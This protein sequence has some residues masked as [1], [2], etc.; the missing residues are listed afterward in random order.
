MILLWTTRFGGAE[1][2]IFDTVEEAVRAAKYRE[3]YGEAG[4]VGIERDGAMLPESEWQP[5]WDGLVAEDDAKWRSHPKVLARVMVWPSGGGRAAVWGEVCEGDH[6]DS[7]AVL[8]K[9]Q[10][11]F[12]ADRCYLEI[13]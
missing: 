9:A 4:F 2:D 5:I 10:A 11:R 1:L 13:R 7:A 3:D 6:D 8:A 12:G